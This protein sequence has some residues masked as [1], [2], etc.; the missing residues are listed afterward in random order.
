MSPEDATHRPVG[1]A[2]GP[3]GWLYVTDDLGGR[4]CRILYTG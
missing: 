3:D 2:Q 4:L 1:I